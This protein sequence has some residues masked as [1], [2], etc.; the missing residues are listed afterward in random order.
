MTGPRC[1]GP[2][3]ITAALLGV[4]AAPA[5]AATLT[6]DHQ[7]SRASQLMR[8]TAPSSRTCTCTSAGRRS[9]KPGIYSSSVDLSPTPDS[10]VEGAPQAGLRPLFVR[11]R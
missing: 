10:D 2:A 5:G 1:I 3:A 4:L 8:V 7:C 11:R 6:T 9:P